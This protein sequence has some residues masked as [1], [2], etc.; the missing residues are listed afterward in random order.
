MYLVKNVPSQIKELDNRWMITAD[1]SRHPIQ[2]QMVVPITLEGRTRDM[3]VLIVPS[4]KYNLILGV[5]F[6]NVM[7]LVM[8]ISNKT[9]QFAPSNPMVAALEPVGGLRTG[10]HLNPEQKLQLDGLIKGHFTQREGKLGRTT[11]VEHV[12]DTGDSSH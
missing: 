5:D 7:Q 8:D 6:W 1:A 4:L 11:L 2:G 9:W 10:E 3:L 12:I